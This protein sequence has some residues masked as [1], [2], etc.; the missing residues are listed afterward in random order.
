MLPH[1]YLASTSPRRQQLLTLLGVPFTLLRCEAE[2]VDE[3][4]L[5]GETP[6]DYVLRLA[7]AKAWAG[8]HHLA[9]TPSAQPALVLGADTTVALGKKLLGKPANAEEA[10]TMLRQLSGTTHEVLTAVALADGNRCITALSRAQVRF[11]PLP[12]AWIDAYLASGEPFD[13]AGGYAYQGAAAAFIPEVRGSASGIVGLPLYETA[14]L[15]GQFGLGP[16]AVGR[17][18]PAPSV[19]SSE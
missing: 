9:P 10:R 5:P 17:R 13:K 12:E 7:Q 18:S 8:W 15:L 19:G 11:A 4:P 3:T 14:A 6:A 1:L 2:W 16:H